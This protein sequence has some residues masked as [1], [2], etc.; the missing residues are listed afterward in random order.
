MPM[1][2]AAFEGVAQTAGSKA[3]PASSFFVILE[4]TLVGSPAVS[5]CGVHG[6]I[7]ASPAPTFLSSCDCV[8][9]PRPGEAGVAHLCCQPAVPIHV[10]L[11]EDVGDGVS[12][13][14]AVSI[15]A[16]GLECRCELGL[17]QPVPIRVETHERLC[18]CLFHRV[19]LGCS[20]PPLGRFGVGKGR[21]LGRFIGA[22][23]HCLS[24][25]LD[26]GSEVIGE[27]T[28]SHILE[29]RDGRTSWESGQGL[30]LLPAGPPE[31][32]GP[33]LRTRRRSLCTRCM[34]P[35]RRT[36]GEDV[37]EYILPGWQRTYVQSLV[38]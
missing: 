16:E 29:L 4:R 33:L 2:V 9:G 36:S 26:S 14:Y 17:V 22:E 31:L 27:L 18:R 15:H 38:V 7:G 6:G 11:S 32:Q 20:G 12:H 13:F 10:A 30:P 37:G 34:P 21:L 23:R 3:Q 24:I 8:G 19:A 35:S 5:S 28:L 25:T 1:T